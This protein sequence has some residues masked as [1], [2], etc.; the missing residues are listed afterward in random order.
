[1]SIIKTTIVTTGF[2]TLKL[3]KNMVY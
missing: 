3:D 2:L 1:M